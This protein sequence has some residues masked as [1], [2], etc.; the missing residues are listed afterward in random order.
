MVVQNT[1]DRNEPVEL[2]VG[3]LAH[4]CEKYIFQALESILKQEHVSFE[5]VLLDDGSNDRTSDIIRSVKDSRVAMIGHSTKRGN[6]SCQ[7]TIIQQS[8]APYIAFLHG[9]QIVLPGALNRMVKILKEDSTIGQVYCYCLNMNGQAALSREDIRERKKQ[10]N[11][12]IIQNEIHHQTLTLLDVNK[13]GL[14]TFRREV[15]D[16]VGY[17][18]ESLRYQ[19]ENDMTLR[20]L[21][22]YETCLVP[23][24][25]CW[26]MQPQAKGLHQ[27]H[28]KFEC[29]LEA[30][31]MVLPFGMPESSQNENPR[32][33]T[34]R[35]VLLAPIYH[36]GEMIWRARKT[37]WRIQS[38]IKRFIG[39]YVRS[40]G[41]RLYE[42]GARGLSSW[43]IPVR[44]VQSTCTEKGST[45]VGYYLWQFPVL[46]QTFIDREVR[47]LRES[48]IP[49]EV[50]AD[51]HGDVE[52]LD[53]HARALIDSTTYIFPIDNKVARQYIGYFLF[54]T[55][56][57]FV[58]L[59]CYVIGHRYHQVKTF[60]DDMQLFLKA[61][62]LAGLY[63]DLNVTR[64]HSPWANRT[65]FVSLIASQLLQVPF[66]VQARASDIHRRSDRYALEEKFANAQLV[67]TNTRFNHDYLK[68]Y[69][70]DKKWSSIQVIYNG[71]DLAQFIP[72]PRQDSAS[73]LNIL[74]V[75]RLIEPKGLVYLLGACRFLKDKK[76][77][78]H[79]EIIGGSQEADLAY[80]IRL[81]KL[82]REFGLEEYVTFSGAQPFSHVLTRYQASDI[83]IL[84]CVQ[85]QDGSQDI[86]PNALIEAMAMKLAVVSTQSTAIPEIVDDGVNGLLVPPKN[87]LALVEALMKLM[88]DGLLR[89]RLGEQAR[90]KIEQRFDIKKNV[91][92][93]VDCFEE[94]T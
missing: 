20:M 64:V 35:S 61:V 85:A 19:Y 94:K 29:L 43:P 9:D 44:K 79:C 50:V 40:L 5:L 4:N 78:F 42:R 53:N 46:S 13:Y 31:R 86:T 63:K 58:S 80:F 30:L 36:V 21:D 12:K 91:S 41:K 60:Q 92:R 59:L 32:V 23:K 62:F 89:T 49:V 28:H 68:Q 6:A 90:R 77:R 16:H 24:F 93:W 70:T 67:V 54:R 73:T 51:K 3:V 74:S 15:F 7:N 14:R 2:T 56:L 76:Y 83:F 69:V 71:L 47:A 39:Q 65:A 26:T 82:R 57:I 55:P 8:R 18:P 10:V 45:R 84:P 17:F 87:E 34:I 27:I 25:F 75:G 48:G 81:K 33:L 1:S 88:N 52:V 72:Q 38:Q 22:R 11:Q 37:K 66:S